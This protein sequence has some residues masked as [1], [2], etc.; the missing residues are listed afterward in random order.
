[1]T[2][3]DRPLARVESGGS[4]P[5]SR[6]DPDVAINTIFRVLLL[7]WVLGY[8]FVSCVPLLTGHLIIGGIT[9]I[10][11][12]IF[13]VPWLLGVFVLGALVWMTNRRVP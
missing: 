4:I 11:G 2:Q 8:L 9:F 7:I 1:M 3:A 10:A 13:L 5:A 12:V 6:Y